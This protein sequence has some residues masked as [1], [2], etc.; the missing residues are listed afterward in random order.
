MLIKV[1][2][3]SSERVGKADSNTRSVC[4]HADD[5]RPF[6]TPKG[7]YTN[8]LLVAPDASDVRARCRK[9]AHEYA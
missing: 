2:Q 1:L 5:V 7:L 8:A 6:Y 3:L 4:V 9:G